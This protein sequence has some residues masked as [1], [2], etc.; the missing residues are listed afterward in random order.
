VKAE[1]KDEENALNFS[2]YHPL[3]LLHPHSTKL[4]KLLIISEIFRVKK[5][6]L[7][8]IVLGTKVL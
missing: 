4:R 7:L 5:N 3:M 2:F 8:G 6:F 1:E